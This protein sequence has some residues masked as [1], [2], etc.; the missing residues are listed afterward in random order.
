MI[1]GG[2]PATWPPNL[3]EER[4]DAF[5]AGYES[6][7]PIDG[8]ER[9]CIPPLMTEALIA[10]CVPPITETGSVGQWA[11]FRVLLMVRRKLRW[12]MTN[13]P[14]LGSKQTA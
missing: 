1:A 3:D 13:A 8:A 5:L 4:Y 11:G 7:L 10:E 14:R 6:L 12:I 9:A 2:D